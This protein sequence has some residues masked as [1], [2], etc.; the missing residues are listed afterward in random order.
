[1]SLYILS[2]FAFASIKFSSA[3]GNSLTIVAVGDVLVHY[4]LLVK[5]NKSG[6]ESLWKSTIPYIQAADIAYANLEGPI[7]V[8]IS[9]SGKYI[10][11]HNLDTR[12]YSGYPTF[13]YPFNLGIALKKSGFDIVSTA[14][15]HALDRFSIGVNKTIDA[16]QQ[17]NI[18]YIGTRMR[19][20]ASPWVKVLNKNGFKIAW[21][22]CT[23]MTN[24]VDDK[25]HQ[26]LKC[27]HKNDKQ[28][29]LN[30][31]A[32]I[33]NN[34]DA[35][36]ITP[37]WGEEYQR[38]PTSQQKNF[39]HE[40]LDAGAMAV[41]GSHP[42]VLQPME[43]YVTKNGRSTFIMYSL[44][45]FISFQGHP[46]KQSTVILLLKLVKT[47]QQTFINTVHYIPMVMQNRNGIKNLTLC[48][49][50][51]KNFNSY[52]YNNIF[53]IF[54]R[55]NVLFFNRNLRSADCLQ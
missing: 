37:H 22:A 10:K 11:T 12:V 51:S 5:G 36:I 24:G 49:I 38:Y 20:D 26:V 7:A 47:P 30:I 42:H 3:N 44:G 2:G 41:I 8:N 21:L 48:P 35:I 25:Y 17:L 50:S 32:T 13:N 53:N 27:Y 52:P 15:N 45:N 31:I 33:K 1:M 14:N 6:F 18:T 23:E 54:P 34:V 29:I 4:P 46:I 43:K 28:Q 39:A 16:L 19:G 9:E 55:E 40:V